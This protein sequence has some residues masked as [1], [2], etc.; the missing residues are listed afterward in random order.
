MTAASMNL[1]ASPSHVLTMPDGAAIAVWVSSE[2]DTPAVIFVHGLPENRL[3]WAP[4]LE[5][6]QAG[7]R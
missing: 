4:V 5:R 3:C 6:L 1:A 7:G 2:D